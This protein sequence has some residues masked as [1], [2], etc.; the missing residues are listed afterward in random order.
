MNKFFQFLSGDFLRHPRLQ[1]WYPFILLLILLAV[2]SIVNEKI[3]NQK[4]KTLERKRYEYKMA[5][6]QLKKNNHYLPYRQQ[7]II[8]E[9]ASKRGFIENHKGTYKIVV[10]D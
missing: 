4:S 9:K 8:R 5:L 1:K 2:I 7:K 6:H 3:I 10:S